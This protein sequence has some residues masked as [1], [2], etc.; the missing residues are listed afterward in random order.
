MAS[1]SVDRAQST[2]LSPVWLATCLFLCVLFLL[3]VVFPLYLER[4]YAFD[5]F[6]HKYLGDVAYDLNDKETSGDLKED[7]ETVK[8]EMFPTGPS[9]VKSPDALYRMTEKAL[10][11]LPL[12]F[13]DL[14][15]L[16]GDHVGNVDD[17]EGMLNKK[18]GPAFWRG[19]AGKG[20][21]DRILVTRRHWYNACRWYKEKY[22]KASYK[23]LSDCFE[24]PQS[25][26]K[27]IFWA[28]ESRLKQEDSKDSSISSAGYH[29]SRVELADFEKLS[30]YVDLAKRNKNHF[31]VGSWKEYIVAHSD[32]LMEAQYYADRL[33]QSKVANAQN[34]K[35]RA[36]KKKTEAL[37]FLKKAL[38][39]EGFAQHFLHDS[40]SSGHIRSEYG[41]CWDLQEI[42]P[43]LSFIPPLLCRPTKELLQH[44]HDELNRIGIL[45]SIRKI[46]KANQSAEETKM[47]P[48]GS[49]VFSWIAYGDRSLLIP[50]AE[51][52]KHI[53]TYFATESVREVFDVAK[54]EKKTTGD[55]ANSIDKKTCENW[56]SRFPMPVKNDQ[57][58]PKYDQTYCGEIV[59][60][61]YSADDLAKF[62]R[63]TWTGWKPSSSAWAVSSPSSW[64]VH[65]RSGDYR[66]PD[67]P[68]EGWKIMVTFGPVFGRFDS[69][70]SAIRIRVRN[71][72]GTGIQEFGVTQGFNVIGGGSFEMGYI[73]ST[74]EWWSPNYVGFGFFNVP[75]YRTS[76]YP[77][78]LGYWWAPSSRFYFLGLRSNV[79]A[80]LYES[81]I[82]ENVSSS[83]GAKLESN[84]V[85]DA[86]I[87]IYPPV[88]FYVR[89]ELVTALVA[90]IGSGVPNE[91]AVDSFFSNGHGAITFGIRFDLAQVL[92]QQ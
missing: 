21:L 19:D 92:S 7:L 15:A 41:S 20:E 31:P 74:G 40:F 56:I 65:S 50:E 66:V 87:E 80:R 46:P 17:L 88:A 58:A 9:P 22:D 35:E 83:G 38:L 48:D 30:D 70:G 82:E 26:E 89:T 78:S 39:N 61:G 63:S 59:K 28:L 64:P 29:P 51:A 68:L 5:Y 33:T 47:S 54:N 45:V 16:A 37:E 13:G 4:C 10:Q 27:V 2:F 14:A 91:V 8:R 81:H 53:L 44:T 32:A 90:G 49:K 76:L 72:G 3:C 36:Q 79:G 62:S 67:L 42:I 34:E 73:R 69:Y 1:T 11:E 77:L 52:H 85:F 55:E 6:E 86:G 71:E 12:S 24:K 84:I 75:G 18:L 43:L 25:L 23:E 57:Y 60:A